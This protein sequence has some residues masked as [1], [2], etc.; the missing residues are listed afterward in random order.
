VSHRA[1]DRTERARFTLAVALVGCGERRRLFAR[2]CLA[3]ARVATASL[4]ALALLLVALNRVLPFPPWMWLAMAILSLSEEVFLAA[5]SFVLWT[6]GAVG[7][8]AAD[9]CRVAD[10]DLEARQRARHF[11]EVA[12][13]E[14]AS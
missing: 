10:R 11:L 6:L 2:G 7:R 13:R 1:W 3:A 5:M 8:E 12:S 14:A 9:F 4:R